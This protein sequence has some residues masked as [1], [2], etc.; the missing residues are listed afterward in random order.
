MVAETPAASK[1]VVVGDPNRQL[2]VASAMI[3][4]SDHG[5]RWVVSALRS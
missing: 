2:K 4:I 3:G 1:E 5:N